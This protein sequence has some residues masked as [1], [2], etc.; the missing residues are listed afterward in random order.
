MVDI[1]AT[2][3]CSGTASGVSNNA[4][5]KLRQE[6]LVAQNASIATVS[7]AT[8]TSATYRSLLQTALDAAHA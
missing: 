2:C 5:V 8:Y 1:N 7:G 6:A 4:F 3:F